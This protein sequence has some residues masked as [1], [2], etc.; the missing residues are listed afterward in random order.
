MSHQTDIQQVKTLVRRQ[1]GCFCDCDDADIRRWERFIKH[2]WLPKAWLAAGRFEVEQTQPE[3][4]LQ[5]RFL[6][7]T[8][9][10]H[11]PLKQG[12]EVVH[13]ND[14]L[15]QGVM[16]C[17]AKLAFYFHITWVNFN[18][19]KLIFKT[20]YAEANIMLN[21]L[22]LSVTKLTCMLSAGGFC[23]SYDSRLRRALSF[24]LLFRVG[25]GY[26]GCDSSFNH[27]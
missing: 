4:P 27:K 3:R 10:L 25:S 17:T 24:L 18:C 7:R 19:F 1:K 21:G 23:F 16:E 12:Q 8:N 6:P 9:M 22:S 2:R 5:T 14:S 20:F 13:Q 15:C 26:S 11:S